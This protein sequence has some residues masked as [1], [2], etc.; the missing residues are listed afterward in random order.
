MKAARVPNPSPLLDDY[1]IFIKAF[2]ERFGDS[3]RKA[4]AANWLRSAQLGKRSIPE[5]SLWVK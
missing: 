2:E 4:H 1:T 3:M 5:F